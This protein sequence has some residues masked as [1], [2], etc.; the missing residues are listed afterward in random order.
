MNDSFA[1]IVRDFACININYKNSSA[2]FHSL[3]ADWLALSM[4]FDKQYL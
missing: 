2:T 4:K 1:P 3:K